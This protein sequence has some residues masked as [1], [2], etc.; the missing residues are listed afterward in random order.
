MNAPTD[1]DRLALAIEQ[2]EAERRRREDERI[3]A[4]TAIRLPLD[5]VAPPGVDD[6]EELLAQAKSAK[7]AAARADGDDREILFEEPQVLVTGVPRGDD[8]GKWEHKLFE[9]QYPD[10]YAATTTVRPRKDDNDNVPQPAPKDWKSIRVQVTAP[11]EATGDPGRVI[12]AEYVAVGNQ[13]RVRY[14]G[15][16]YIETFTLGDDPLAIA[17]RLLRAKW[18]KHGGDFYAPIRYPTKGYH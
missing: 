7:L 18:D 11:N 17:R 5:V 15:R 9:P 6:I 12:E 14:D 13:V 16:G 3:A 2:L 8:F 4:G 10:R 1:A